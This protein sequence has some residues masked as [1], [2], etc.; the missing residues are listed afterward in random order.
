M[1][2]LGDNVLGSNRD[3][4]IVKSIFLAPLFSLVLMG[5][6]VAGIVIYFFTTLSSDVMQDKK[7]ML[8]TYHR[9]VVKDM[10]ESLRAD[11]LNI[12]NQT[13][14]QIRYSLKQR[15][16]EATVIIDRIIKENPDDTPEEIKKKIALILGSIRYD[17]GN[18]YYFAYDKATQISLI[19]PL[20]KFI[21][22]DMRH[23]RDK[24]GTLLNQLFERVVDNKQNSG[25]AT[26]YFTKPD[27]PSKEYK[28]ITYVRY[29]KKLNWIIGTGKYVID[30]KNE[31]EKKI[32]KRIGSKKYG[33]NGYFWVNDTKGVLLAH[34][35]LK[36]RIGTNISDLKDINGVSM[37]K[38]FLTNAKKN[39]PK[40]AYI[41]YYWS[42]PSSKKVVK[43]LSYVILIKKLNW[44]IG[45]GVYLDDVKKSMQASND[46]MIETLH[47]LLLYMLIFF[48]ISF[49]IIAS[50]SLYLSKISKTLFDIYK[51]DLE[52]RIK[53]ASIQF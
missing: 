44:I 40:G 27:S 7:Q 46:T 24:R 6:V 18:G 49:M 25:Y 45:T 53:Q 33:K 9:Q 50:L 17:H 11:M 23:F 3:K 21:G 34:P 29:I 30:M 47:K 51:N 2:L 13:N 41:E 36:S 16:D 10:A 31:L 12:I 19:H 26:I 8:I 15:I 52:K 42:K 22:K 1:A 4:K 48:A 39:Y 28:K 20:K 5:I 43:K 32:L 37:I 14:K 35:Y 38:L